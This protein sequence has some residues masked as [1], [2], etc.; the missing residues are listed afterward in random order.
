MLRD[1]LSWSPHVLPRRHVGDVIVE[2]SSRSRG[3]RGIVRVN[4]GHRWV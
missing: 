3:V 2:G 1:E 4:V